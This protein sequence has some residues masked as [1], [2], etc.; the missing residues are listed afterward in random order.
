VAAACRSLREGRALVSFG[1]LAHLVVDGRAGPGDLALRGQRGVTA[2]VT[3]LGPPWVQAERVE[4]FAN[5][6]RVAEEKLA[7]GRGVTKGR[8]TFKLPRFRHDAHLVAIASGP[9]V[10]A[11]FWETPRPYQPNSKLFNPRVLGATNPVWVDGDSDGKFTSARSYAEQLVARYG[12][13]PAKLVPA[14]ASCDEAVAAQAASLC[15][16]AGV[17]LRSVEAVRAL[18]QATRA[19]LHGWVSY[20][21]TVP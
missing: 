6:L 13:S 8:V 18:R 16:A 3:V 14:L 20:A 15:H 21:G 17:D 19:V 2:V 5:G 4:L 12:T 10:A 1:L 7:P 11:P 9:G